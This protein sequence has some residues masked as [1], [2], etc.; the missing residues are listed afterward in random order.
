MASGSFVWRCIAV[1]LGSVAVLSTAELDDFCASNESPVVVNRFFL[2]RRSRDSHKSVSWLN[3]SIWDP[4]RLPLLQ[5]AALVAIIL[6]HYPRALPQRCRC[7]DGH[8]KKVD[9]LEYVE[10]SDDRGVPVCI[11]RW[12]RLDSFCDLLVVAFQRVE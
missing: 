9:S 11:D 6:R 4:F 3:G 7:W 10:L 2:L 5:S 1:P 8:L 12:W